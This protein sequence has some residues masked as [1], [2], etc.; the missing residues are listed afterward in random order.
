M[1]ELEEGFSKCQCVV[2]KRNWGVSG[3][4]IV[5]PDINGFQINLL[6][7]NCLTN[8]I[9]Y[10]IGCQKCQQWY[11]GQTTRHFKDTFKEH[12]LI[13][14]DQRKKLEDQDSAVQT[15]SCFTT[16]RQDNRTSSCSVASFPWRKPK[17]RDFDDGNVFRGNLP[18]LY[19]C[20]IADFPSLMDRISVRL[21]DWVVLF[22][23]HFCRGRSS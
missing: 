1:A 11:I 13:P 9:I 23:F 3:S 17:W 12:Q 20:V 15:L 5:S 2:C 7:T 6:H 22:V 18:N 4:T 21:R 19:V 8:N 10:L 14:S 16:W